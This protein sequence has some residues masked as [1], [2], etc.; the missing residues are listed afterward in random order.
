MKRFEFRNQVIEV[1]NDDKPAEQIE[2]LVYDAIGKDPWTG[3]GVTCSEMRKMLND[4]CPAKDRELHLRINSKGGDV[5]EGMAIK[6]MLDE[7]PKDVYATI[8]GVAASTA[9]WIPLNCKEVRA[10][11]NSQVFIHDAIGYGGGNA[12]DFRDFADK[13]DKTSD[14]I[15]GMYA[16][17]TGKGK[18]TMRA[19]M[20]D[21]TLLTG[22]EAEDLGLVDKLIDGKALRNFMP[23]ELTSMKNQLW[24]IYNSA[25]REASAN[26]NTKPV[27]NKEQ[28]LALLKEHGVTVANEATDEQLQAALKQLLNKKP[29]A[30]KEKPAPEKPDNKSGTEAELI[31]LRNDIAQLTEANNAAKK[32]R[33]TGEVEALVNEDKIPAAIKDSI[34]TQALKDET[35]LNDLKKL[36][37]K[38]PGGKPLAAMVD[39]VGEAFADVQSFILNTGPRFTSKNLLGEHNVEEVGPQMLRELG[40]RSIKVANTYRKHR[41]MLLEM[42]NTNT[43]DTDLKRIVFL[44]EMLEE[45]VIPL[46]PLQGFSSVFQNVPLEGTDKVGVPFYPLQTAAATSFVTGNGYDTFQNTTTNIREVTVGGAGSTG[47]G[48]NAAANTA[49]D[50]LYLGLAFDSYTL[51]RQPFFNALKLNQQNANKLAVDVFKQIVSRVITA[52]NYGVSI[53]N[54]P[55]GTFAGDD[56]ADLWEKV[57]GLNWPTTGRQLVLDHTYN[58]PLLKDPTFK[59]YL[60]AGTTD[61]LRK[62][63]IQEVYGFESIPIVPNLTT[64]SPVG[65]NLVGWVNWM[66]AMLVATAPIM[67]SPEVRNLLTRYDVVTDPKTGISFEYRQ[68]ANAT[69]D[70]AQYLIECNFGAAVGVASALARLTKP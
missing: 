60:S 54:V 19:M 2:M 64:Y 5:H 29:E 25:A 45:F 42:A 3:G 4:I 70:Q 20:Q 13:L 49:N 69:L 48:A 59:Q 30:E 10:F 18:R 41:P 62:A 35:I 7:W 23:E 53:K 65:E 43:I 14:Q 55:P 32:L 24:A 17:A 37:S 66:Y 15:A 8:D 57:T 61:A 27:M 28:M 16:D 44:Q 46:L 68:M 9:S 31:K 11:K 38:P 52:G 56:I 50:R 1:S 36:E 33:I 40:G 39:C 26:N 6:N 22:E 58:T 21:E 12:D 34:V 47:S 63:K 51:R 67:P